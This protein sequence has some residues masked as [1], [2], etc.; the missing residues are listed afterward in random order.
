MYRKF[1]LF[2]AA[3]ALS[4]CAALSSVSDLVNENPL[5]VD[6]TVSQA[7]SRVIEAQDDT[8]AAAR[9]T[10]RVMDNTLLFID[11]NPKA[12]IGEVVSQFIASINWDNMTVSDRI[13]VET[14]VKD[15]E[16]RLLERVADGDLPADQLVGIRS[17]IATAK[18]TAQLFL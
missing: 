8:K 1:I 6:I 7:T 3:L 18:R 2:L 11:K 4:G 9:E 14:V 12:I 16:R 15:V 5:M 10:I 17:V 13:L